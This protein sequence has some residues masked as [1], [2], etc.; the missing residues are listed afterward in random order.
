[1]NLRHI[2]SALLAA[3]CLSAQETGGSI[4]FV[5]HYGAT[6]ALLDY[7]YQMPAMGISLN[8]Q[9]WTRG[10]HGLRFTLEGSTPQAQTLRLGDRSVTR[11][12]SGWIGSVD[13]VHTFTFKS[14][15]SLYGVLGAA[16]TG[17][18]SHS[19][20]AGGEGRATAKSL[21]AKVGLGIPL[22]WPHG[23]LEVGS[24]LNVRLATRDPYMPSDEGRGQLAYITILTRF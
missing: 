13:Y 19:R 1:L 14:G 11:S 17:L 12:L 5:G 4:G 24:L 21:A 2:L 10:P 8:V 3:C 7:G 23:W 9:P 15:S 18:S 6:G 20:W 16:G 22:L